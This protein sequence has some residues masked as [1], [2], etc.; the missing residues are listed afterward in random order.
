MWFNNIL[1]DNAMGFYVL[2]FKNDIIGQLRLD[3]D[4][5]FPVISISLN[6]NIGV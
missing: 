3:F 6:K 2:E 1:K 4:D 5:D